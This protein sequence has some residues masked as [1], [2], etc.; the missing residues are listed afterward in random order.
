MLL[1]TSYSVKHE[2]V[3][4][5]V[6]VVHV[7]ES[8]D[9]DGS[10]CCLT[11]ISFTPSPRVADEEECYLKVSK[12]A[13]DDTSDWK[14]ARANTET[15]ENDTP[16]IKINTNTLPYDVIDD[17]EVL[18]MY[19]LDAFEATQGKHAGT[20]YLFGKVNTMCL[21]LMSHILTHLSLFLCRSMLRTRL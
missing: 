9:D 14:K 8:D 7:E 4:P 13:Q 11:L 15:I 21:P 5:T 10:V 1:L 17:K 12:P 16:D 3:K 19:W 20:V 2:D 6:S 18:H